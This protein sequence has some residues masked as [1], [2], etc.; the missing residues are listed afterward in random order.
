MTSGKSS[1]AVNRA[2]QA[3]CQGEQGQVMN[4]VL[5]REF[6]FSDAQ[7]ERLRV[8]VIQHTGIALTQA[9]KDM[10]YSRLSKR[11]RTEFQGS[12]A[13]FCD[14]VDGG[15]EQ[16]REFLINA[17]TTNLT[18]FFREQHHFDFLRDRLLPELMKQNAASRRIRI[19]S[20]G[21]STGEEPYSIAMTL[22]Q[23]PELADWDVRIL[24]TDLDA[25]VINH[26]REGVYTQERIRDLPEA[27]Q[28]RWFLRGKTGN[29]GLVKVKPQLQQW[30]Q[31]KRLNLLHDWPMRGP[32]D[33]IFCR[34]VVIYFDKAT[35]SQLF[36]RYA[37]ILQPQGHLFIGHSESL[38]KVCDRFSSL[39][40]TIY[41]RLR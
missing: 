36:D 21:C 18:A 27:Q 1:E 30:I 17:I 20:A 32:F 11:I 34:N 13:A 5:E 40:H 38:F 37:D 9:K 23:I 3:A 2:A 4:A 15:D 31:F 6:V 12:F 33:L 8:F 29:S 10:V 41:R 25:N 14:A 19:W 39:G 28:Q 26:A 7:F 22:A 24:A 16:E 35:Q